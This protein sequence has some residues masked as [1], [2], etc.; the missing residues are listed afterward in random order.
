MIPESDSRGRD[1]Q[2]AVGRSFIPDPLPRTISPGFLT[3]CADIPAMLA[4]H[5]LLKQ[6]EQF[7]LIRAFS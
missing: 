7:S 4:G 6:Y 2:T 3:L 5:F 1:K